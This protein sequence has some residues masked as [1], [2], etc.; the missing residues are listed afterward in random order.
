M[1]SKNELTGLLVG[2]NFRPPAKLFLEC[3]PAG[4]ELSL[5]HEPSNEYDANAVKV[6]VKL[7]EIP[8]SQ[9]SRLESELPGFGWSM[10]DFFERV[11]SGESF[12]LGYLAASKNKQLKTIEGAVS[13]EVFLLAQEQV[14]WSECSIKLAFGMNG[15]PLVLLKAEEQANV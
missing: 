2:M 5:E 15:L 8:A 3:L 13:N 10:E 12:M 11:A 7:G 9:A 1:S 14:A 4:S 6:S